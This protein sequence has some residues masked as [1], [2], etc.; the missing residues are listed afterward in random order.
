MLNRT[1]H[2]ATS[3]PWSGQAM[4]EEHSSLDM[5]QQL[6]HA[7]LREWQDEARELRQ[8]RAATTRPS[9]RMHES[10]EPQP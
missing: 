3:T 7:Q 5:I 9:S 10:E 8:D 2:E 6:L 4:D 1:R